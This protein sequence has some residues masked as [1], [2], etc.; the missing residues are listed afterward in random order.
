MTQYDSPF[1]GWIVP[2]PWQEPGFDEDEET[3][4]E[5]QDDNDQSDY[6]PD[7]EFTL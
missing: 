2:Q 1:I 4:E 3:N 7:G 5:D 6:D